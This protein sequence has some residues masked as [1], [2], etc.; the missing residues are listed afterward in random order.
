M[1]PLTVNAL[2]KARHAGVT[3]SQTMLM[4]ERHNSGRDM[5]AFFRLKGH[6]D[7]GGHTDDGDALALLD[8]QRRVVEQHA[9]LVPVRQL[10]DAQRPLPIGAWLDAV[11]S[12]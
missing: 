12:I 2:V 11:G 7:Y 5:P 9:V 3:P 6:R 10:L 8:L 1:P 4:A